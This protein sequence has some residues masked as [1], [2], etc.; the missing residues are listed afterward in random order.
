M[1]PMLV[2]PSDRVEI[3]IILLLIVHCVGLVIWDG[4]R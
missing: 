1:A 2:W 4:F 3:M